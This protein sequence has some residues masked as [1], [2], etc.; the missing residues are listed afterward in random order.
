MKKLFDVKTDFG[1]YKVNVIVDRYYNNRNLAINLFDPV[2][3]P[4]ARLTVNIV[5]LKPGLAFVD[6]NNCPWAEEFIAE[7]KLGKPTGEFGRSGRC[8]Y[9]LYEFD[10]DALN[11]EA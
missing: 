6:T 9:P 5:K 4:F 8:I 3:G 2:E 10:M 11:A 7:H 1:S